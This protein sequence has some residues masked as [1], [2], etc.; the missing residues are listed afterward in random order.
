M[1]DLFYTYGHVRPDTGVIFYVGK[2]KKKRAWSCDHRN[3]HWHRIV[4]KNN[5]KFEVIIFNWFNDEKT[6]FDSEIWQIAELK[7]LGNL[8]NET[9][10]GE[11]F[12][13]G[14]HTE[15]TKKKTSAR[16]KGKALSEDHCAKLRK[17]KSEACRMSMKEASLYK[18]GKPLFD[19]VTLSQN[20][21]KLWENP[22]YRAKQKESR[23]DK[24]YT[25][26]SFINKGK[27][28]SDITKAK[29]RETRNSEIVQKQLRDAMNSRWSNPNF[30]YKMMFRDWHFSNV[31]TRYYWGA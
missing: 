14:R 23:K 31:K 18:K 11:G 6:A 27:K 30:R 7:P 21:I 24:D 28:A 15:E 29:M 10:G 1:S 17:P 4:K 22:A 25:F 16:F 12:C 9:D 8:S 19:D 20:S 26:L 13:G 2:G 5:L 3:E